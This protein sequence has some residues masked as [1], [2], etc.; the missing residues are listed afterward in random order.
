MV[1]RHPA[2]LLTLEGPVL[3][4]SQDVKIAT[5]YAQSLYFSQTSNKINFR[6]ALEVA[7]ALEVEAAVQLVPVA[8][9]HQVRAA[10]RA[11]DAEEGRYLF[12]DIFLP[13]FF[14]IYFS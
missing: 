4:L 6:F 3:V 14:Q 2:F 1:L 5:R 9:A 12:I 10:Q 7:A 8:V 13:I 11:G